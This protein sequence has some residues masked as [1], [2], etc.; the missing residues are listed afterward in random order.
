MIPVGDVQRGAACN[1]DRSGL[2]RSVRE[3]NLQ[4]RA[5]GVVGLL[6][7]RAARE[8]PAEGFD[9]IMP[10]GLRNGCRHGVSPPDDLK[11][12]LLDMLFDPC[13]NPY[14]YGVIV[15]ATFVTTRF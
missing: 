13:F 4:R 15:D 10:G 8:E 11:M 1:Q 14:A 7:I 9:V 5:P 6:D 3:R 2:E 12:I